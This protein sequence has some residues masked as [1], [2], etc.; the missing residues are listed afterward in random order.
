LHARLQRRTRL[1]VALFLPFECLQKIR[2][3]ATH[4]QHCN[5]LQTFANVAFSPFSIRMR[6]S[7]SRFSSF[8]VCITL[9]MRV[10]LDRF[11]VRSS[12]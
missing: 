2:L 10:T 7:D 5:T 4:R 9:W 12:S 3:D 6:F 8:I 11:F 1:I